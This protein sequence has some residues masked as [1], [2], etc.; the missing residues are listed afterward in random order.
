M[1]NSTTKNLI[2]TAL[3]ICGFTTLSSAQYL[4]SNNV[5]YNKTSYNNSKAE[6][7][8][9]TISEK[10]AATLA[11]MRSAQFVYD[12]LA[13]LK[14]N[15][16]VSDIYFD[17]DQA[18]IR[19]DAKPVLDEL[20]AL[21]YEKADI[22][23]A[24]TAHCDSRMTTYN[25]TLALRRAEAA[26][27]Y[28]ISKGVEA[29]RILVEKHGRPSVVNPCTNNPGCS[30]AEQEKN[31]KTEFNIIYNDVNLAHLSSFND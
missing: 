17:M 22:S 31:R 18:A 28:L 11:Y 10:N 29:E 2:L 1:K 14:K 16:A 26:K 15:F 25:N 4:A 24:V 19:I 20:A 12:N 5:S 7:V 9:S 8:T 30:I 13:S 6:V 23:V 27:A 3:F 21:M